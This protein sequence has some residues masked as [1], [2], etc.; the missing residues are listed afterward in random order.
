M[1][2]PA[3]GLW[4]P[5]G[6]AAAAVAPIGC[7]VLGNTGGPTM[8][9]GVVTGGNHGGT[10]IYTFQLSGLPA[11][12]HAADLAVSAVAS[13]T[14]GEG[15]LRTCTY[16][17]EDGEGAGVDLF[18]F[19]WAFDGSQADATQVSVAVFAAS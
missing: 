4:P 5:G 1:S 12:L 16:A 15:G 14:V 13:Y 19:V 18:V 10:G 9:A 3:Y 8:Q 7:G 17:L 2:N 11:G 6:A